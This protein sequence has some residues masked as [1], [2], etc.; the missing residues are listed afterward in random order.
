MQVGYKLAMEG[1]APREFIRQAV[2]AG[3]DPDGFLD[4]FAREL[5]APMRALTPA[6]LRRPG[7]LARPAGASRSLM[8]ELEK[9]RAVAREHE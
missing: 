8:K 3:P 9:V 5:A 2:L 1:F 7:R 4:F 6:G